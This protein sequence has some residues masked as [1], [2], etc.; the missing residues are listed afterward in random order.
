MMGR[1]HVRILM[2]LTACVVGAGGAGCQR[3]S[4]SAGAGA[5]AR[6]T[7]ERSFREIANIVK[8]GLEMRGG[9]LPSG[10]V[11]RE[12]S[13]RSQFSVLNTVTSQLIP[14]TEPGGIYRGTITITSHSVYSLRRTPDSDIEKDGDLANG[15]QSGPSL[16]DDDEDADSGISVMDDELISAAPDEEKPA[17]GS[18]E[19][20][21]RRAD[22]DV[23]TIDFAYEDD[24]WQLKTKLDPETEQSIINAI[25]RALKLQ[26]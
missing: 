23:R 9:G 26:P 3:E 13:S 12:S 24:R 15:D 21:S 6:V 25:E 2:F 17:A 18:G 4:P 1:V 7:P 20:V 11:A 8:D 14:P 22:E 5:A 16:L 19:T 10:F